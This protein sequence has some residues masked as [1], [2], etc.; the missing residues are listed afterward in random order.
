MRRGAI[1]L[2]HREVREVTHASGW[3]KEVEIWVAYHDNLDVMEIMAQDRSTRKEANRLYFPVN[4]L[5]SERP[6]VRRVE[7]FVERHIALEICPISGNVEIKL[8]GSS[9]LST[10]DKPAYLKPCK[11]RLKRRYKLGKAFSDFL[12]VSGRNQQKIAVATPISSYEASYYPSA[13]NQEVVSDFPSPESSSNS[14]ESEDDTGILESALQWIGEMIGWGEEDDAYNAGERLGRNPSSRARSE[15]AWVPAPGSTLLRLPAPSEF[16]STTTLMPNSSPSSP[17]SSQNTENLS[18]EA[19]H[20]SLRMSLSERPFSS[21]QDSNI[22]RV[23]YR[24]RAADDRGSIAVLITMDRKT[25]IFEIL[26]QPAGPSGAEEGEKKV[27]YIYYEKLLSVVD[28]LKIHHLM[29]ERASRDPTTTIGGR[30][31]SVT[32]HLR[33]ATLQ[34]MTAYL[35]ENLAIYRPRETGPLVVRFLCKNANQPLE[36]LT[37]RP[38]VLDNRDECAGGN[39]RA[40]PLHTICESNGED[41]TPTNRNM[42]SSPVGMGEA[43]CGGNA[44]PRGTVKPQDS[45]S[46]SYVAG[47]LA[48]LTDAIFGVRKSMSVVP[49]S[50]S[51]S[52]CSRSGHDSKRERT[53]PTDRFSQR[54][55]LL[56]ESAQEASVVT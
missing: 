49:M 42:S 39:G 24:D 19:E 44:G 46:T 8:V 14:F 11:M 18:G 50:N 35:V 10:M 23:L 13:T 6:D 2:L 17:S 47:W 36:V 38:E 9:P 48:G 33:D 22:R 29:T 55:E 54:S 20:Q 1:T 40:A 37:N 4:L 25:R 3:T 41:V 5:D 32:N 56:H 21:V 7:Q 45:N 26:I 51:S 28:Q 15:R 30:P 34:V 53:M 43:Q 31:A 52:S 12:G 27:Y 16:N